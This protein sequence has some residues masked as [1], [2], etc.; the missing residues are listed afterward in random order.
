LSDRQE[1]H[2]KCDALA[3][4]RGFAICRFSNKGFLLCGRAVKR[5]G[6]SERRDEQKNRLETAA[7]EG[8][9]GHKIAC[10]AL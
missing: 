5:V 3:I 10:V 7:W 2:K 9:S 4:S 8:R 1:H 6:V